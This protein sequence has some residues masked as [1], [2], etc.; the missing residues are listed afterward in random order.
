MPLVPETA[1]PATTTVQVE[2]KPTTLAKPPLRVQDRRGQ[3]AA[4]ARGEPYEV[5]VAT[6]EAGFLYCYLLEDRRPPSQFFPN[7]KARNAAVGA[8]SVLHFPGGYG[9]SLVASR[10][11]GK[12]TVICANSSKDLGTTPSLPDGAVDLAGM[13]A[14]IERLTEGASVQF[15][16]FDVHAR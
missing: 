5:E 13:K 2:E 11:G 16:A 12:E 7:P 4:Y 8:G 14:Q 9:F 10:K 15:G 3:R 1:P 6:E